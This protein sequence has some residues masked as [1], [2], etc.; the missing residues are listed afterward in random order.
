MVPSSPAPPCTSRRARAHAE[1]P[2]HRGWATTPLPFPPSS[3]PEVLS[4]PSVIPS[5]QT[6]VWPNQNSSRFIS[7]RFPIKSMSCGVFQYL[8]LN[9]RSEHAGFPGTLRLDSG[10]ESW[11]LLGRHALR[12]PAPRFLWE[13]FPAQAAGAPLREPTARQLRVLLTSLLDWAPGKRG[14]WLIFHL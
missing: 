11:P 2:Q 8:Y 12:G 6:Q 14:Q 1:G 3:C 13:V 9:E 4:L 7:Y 10:R 5:E